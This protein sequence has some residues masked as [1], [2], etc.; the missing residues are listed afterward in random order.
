MKKIAIC[1][2]LAL[3]IVN[4]SCKKE[5]ISPTQAEVTASQLQNVIHTNSIHRVVAVGIGNIFPNSFSS[6]EGTVFS[7]SNGFITIS[8]YDES[9]NLAYL[10]SYNI[11]NVNIVNNNGSSAGSDQALILNFKW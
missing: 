4:M 10:V 11:A 9:Y 3:C 8:G 2:L 7:F 5:T 6:T 1:I